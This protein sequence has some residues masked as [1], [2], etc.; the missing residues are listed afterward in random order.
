M[1]QTSLCMWLTGSN[2][3]MKSAKWTPAD[4]IL[5][6]LWN[7]NINLT[8]QSDEYGKWTTSLVLFRCYISNMILSLTLFWYLIWN[9]NNIIQMPNSVH[10]H[11]PEMSNLEHKALVI[12]WKPFMPW[13]NERRYI[14][15]WPTVIPWPSYC[16]PFKA[17]HCFTAS[18]QDPWPEATALLIAY[19]LH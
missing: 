13:R 10:Q 11:H 1:I 4:I 9:T 15:S 14:N 16:S 3:Q 12:S 5:M 2:F 19:D 17:L 7:M 8:L 18:L 6:L